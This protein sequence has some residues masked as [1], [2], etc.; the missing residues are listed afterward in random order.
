MGTRLL[1]GLLWLAVL[2]SALVQIGVVNW[3]RD[4]IQ[5]WQREDGRRAQL[6]E[7]NSRLL[8]ERSTLT[9]H[10]RI[11]QLARKKLNMTEPDKVQ[12]LSQ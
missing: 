8:L 1:T 12:V 5:V 9:A 6:Q 7:E 4:L 10:G 2:V 3:Q 11:D